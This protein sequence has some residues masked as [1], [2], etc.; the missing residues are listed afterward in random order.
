MKAFQCSRC[1]NLLDLGD[2]CSCRFTDIDPR[3]DRREQGNRELC[4]KNF[5]PLPP[6]KIWHVSFS[7]EDNEV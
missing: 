3:P 6:D 1:S 5:D 2:Y 4:L 7:W